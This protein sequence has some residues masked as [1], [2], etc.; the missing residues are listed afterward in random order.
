M[1]LRGSTIT[2]N[3][4]PGASLKDIKKL[5]VNQLSETELNTGNRL[6]EIKPKKLSTIV[7]IAPTHEPYD[8]SAIP[9]ASATK[10]GVQPSAYT[11]T[12]DKTKNNQ[13][14]AVTNPGSTKD[15]S[16]QPVAKAA[17]GNLT[18]DQTTAYYAQMGKS[19]SGGFDPKK[20][21]DQ[22]HVV[23]DYGYVG[24]YQMGYEALIDG[25]LVKSSCKSNAQLNNPNNW[26]GGEGKPAS[27]QEFLDNEAAQEQ[28]MANYTSS[29]YSAMLKT[30]TITKD[31][32]PDQV[33]GVLAVGHL[34]GAGGPPS[35]KYPEGSGAWLWRRGGGGAD[36]NQT[37]GDTY[38]QNG[39]YAVSV[40]G[41][42]VA[43]A[44]TQ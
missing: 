35:K 15:L 34:L 28:Q 33:G 9:T 2:Q 32:P 17:I 6:W 38:F 27:L 24:K 11:G 13:G 29:N 23:N 37:T 21:P 39:K 31:M 18:A 10:P 12:Q 4:D 42:K 7:T 16:K 14:T 40:L 30:G 41:P 3:T 20:F 8:R 19:E 1:S 26:I 22:Y 5:T 36:A 43:S 25:K 44:N